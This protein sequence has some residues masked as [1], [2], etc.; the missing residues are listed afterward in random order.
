MARTVLPFR[1]A[2]PRLSGQ[3][4]IEAEDAIIWPGLWSDPQRE[5]RRSSP[6]PHWVM[7]LDEGLQLSESVL[8]S[9]RER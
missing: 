7:T 9:E 5:D 1:A 4:S 3:S 2:T 6:A 8:S